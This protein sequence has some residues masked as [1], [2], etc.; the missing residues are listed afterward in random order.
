MFSTLHNPVLYYLF[1][2]IQWIPT[3]TKDCYGTEIKRWASCFYYEA[4]ESHWR[5]IIS[6]GGQKDHVKVVFK[7][8]VDE[9][10]LYCHVKIKYEDFDTVDPFLLFDA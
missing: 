6:E 2:N 10:F 7:F 5:V 1:V 8:W 3:G 4:K 9:D